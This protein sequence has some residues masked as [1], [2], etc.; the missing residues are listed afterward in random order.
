MTYE[1]SQDVLESNR[2]AVRLRENEQRLRLATSATNLGVW[3]WDVGRDE[4]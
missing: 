3:E 4:I 2:L 1:L